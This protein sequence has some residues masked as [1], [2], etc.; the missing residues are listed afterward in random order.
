V[1][2]RG[3]VALFSVKERFMPKSYSPEFRRR[4]IELCRSGGRRPREVAEE[5]GVAEATVSI[6]GSP[7]RKSILASGKGFVAASVSSSRRRVRGS[8]SW[9]RSWS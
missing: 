3:W 2:V 9:K 5:V 6:A 8:R 4:V 7:R 1:F